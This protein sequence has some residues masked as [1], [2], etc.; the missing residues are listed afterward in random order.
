MRLAMGEFDGAA[1]SEGADGG[2]GGLLMDAGA[3]GSGG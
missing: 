1:V 3:C 2:A